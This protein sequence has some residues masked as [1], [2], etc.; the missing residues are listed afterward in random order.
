MY[1]RAKRL[2]GGHIHF[3]YLLLSVHF[4]R[5]F[6]QFSLSSSSKIC[7]KFVWGQIFGRNR[8]KILFRVF[9]LAIHSLTDPPGWQATATTPFKSRLYTPS[10]GLYVFGYWAPTPSW[11]TNRWFNTALRSKVVP[12]VKNLEE[13]HP[14]LLS[15]LLFSVLLCRRLDIAG[16]SCYT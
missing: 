12:K 15:S 2:G 11:Y 4:T 1:Y 14:F 5:F 13:A 6:A 10:Q 8:N 7:K 16:C 9:L 3:L